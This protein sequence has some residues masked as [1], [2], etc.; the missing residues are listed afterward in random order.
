MEL[1]AMH[2]LPRTILRIDFAK[3]WLMAFTHAW[4]GR[5][6][7]RLVRA[8]ELPEH[9]RRDIGLLDRPWLR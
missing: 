6:R 9:L 2:I 4:R 7:R 3:G 1:S 5:L 8:D